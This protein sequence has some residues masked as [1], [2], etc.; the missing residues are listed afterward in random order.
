MIK[1]VLLL[2]IL[3]TGEAAHRH[4]IS[5]PHTHHDRYPKPGT[6]C[7]ISESLHLI[8]GLLYIA[9]GLLYRLYVLLYPDHGSLHPYMV[10]SGMF[11]G[12]GTL[13]IGQYPIFMGHCA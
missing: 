11:T 9:H 3:F 7:P 1:V 12:R 4:P 2:N 10:R 5:K 6:A 13:V 8:Y